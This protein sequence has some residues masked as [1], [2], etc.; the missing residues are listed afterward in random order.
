MKINLDSLSRGGNFQGR[1]FSVPFTTITPVQGATDTMY[2]G[3]HKDTSHMTIYKWPDSSNNPS[4][5]NDIHV[6]PWHGSGRSTAHCASPDNN[7]WCNYSINSITSGWIRNG[8][9]G[10]F[11]NVAEN[12]ENGFR[13]PYVDSATFSLSNDGN[14]ISYV[15]RP[16]IWHN[17]YAWMYASAAPNQRGIGI[18]AFVGGGNFYPIVN[19]AIADNYDNP[20]PGWH[21]WWIASSTHAPYSERWGDY[22]R[23]RPFAG[24]IHSSTWIGTGFTL[25][26]SSACADSGCTRAYDGYI[27]GLVPYYFT[28]GREIDGMPITSSAPKT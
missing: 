5:F 24:D 8:Q 4:V 7:N 3:T 9:I 16:Y 11:W 20:P 19:I 22:L 26:G 17:D 23:V 15:A 28:F 10:F 21:M 1:E 18:V 12:T 2:L 6:T 13:Y 27:S 14:T 25:E